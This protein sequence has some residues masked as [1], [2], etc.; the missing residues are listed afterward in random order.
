MCDMLLISFVDLHTCIC[1]YVVNI[2]GGAGHIGVYVLEIESVIGE[3][4][5]VLA[6]HA[7][8]C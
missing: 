6:S 2:R 5:L 4:F 1:T 8:E 3:M 7:T